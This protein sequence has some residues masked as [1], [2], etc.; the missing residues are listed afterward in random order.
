MFLKLNLQYFAECEKDAV[1]EKEEKKENMQK[2]VKDR[3]EEA[4]AWAKE[5][6]KTIKELLEPKQEEKAQQEIP[7]PEAPVTV[8][9][10]EEEEDKPK[11]PSFLSWL[12]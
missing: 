10:V 3:K 8:E 1:Q 2:E 9:E 12:L 4:P 6:T 5:L 11:R 7:V